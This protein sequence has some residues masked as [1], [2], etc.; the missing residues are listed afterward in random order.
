MNKNTISIGGNIYRS[1]KAPYFVA[2]I[3]ANH[4]KDLDRTLALIDVA[5][6]SGANAVKLQTF[7]PQTITFDSNKPDYIVQNNAWEG[8][9]LHQLYDEAHLPWHMHKAIFEHCHKI[10]VDCFSTPF[11]F[12]AVDFLRQFDPPAYKI[13]SSELIDLPLIK[14]VARENKPIIISTGMGNSSEIW[15]AVKTVRQ[16]N[17]D[18]P[19]V[20]LKC[21]AEYPAKIEDAN[22]GCLQEEYPQFNCHVGLSD[23]S[24]GALVPIVAALSG[25]ILIEKHITNSR[26]DGGVDS[27][28]SMEPHEFLQMTTDVRKSISAA[29]NL[30]IDRLT[31]G[32]KNSRKYRKSLIFTS[33][34]NIGQEV[35]EQHVKILRPAI[36]LEPRHYDNVIGLRVRR[37]ISAG[38]PV[39]WSDFERD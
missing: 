6:A 18:L 20:L 7:T 8:K 11:D 3:S 22:L 15:D 4:H 32:E 9:S 30:G 24:H 37:R 28:F 25:A 13:A 14:K 19:I 34:M 31:P 39:K 2:E 35:D 38:D 36:G 1:Y 33:D 23:H 5:K 16:V 17:S 12:T 27:H 21:T 26:S 29:A 10:G